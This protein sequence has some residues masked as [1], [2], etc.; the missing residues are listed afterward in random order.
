LTIR[1]SVEVSSQLSLLAGHTR[2]T[3]TH[4]AREAI[5]DDVARELAIVETVKRGLNDMYAGRVVPHSQAT[6]RLRAAVERAADK[7][8]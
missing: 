3:R 8:S 6:S 1:L 4:L 7:R 2:R 5:I